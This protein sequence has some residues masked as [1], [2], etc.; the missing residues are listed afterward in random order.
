MVGRLN[1]LRRVAALGMTF[2]MLLACTTL[3]RP[4]GLPPAQNGGDGRGLNIGLSA[5]S[6]SWESA[7]RVGGV[8]GIDVSQWQGLINWS[9]V[10]Q[11]NVKYVMARAS[12]GE[13]IDTHFVYNATNAY[14]NGLRVG[15]YHYCKF[16]DETSM[17]RELGALLYQLRQVTIDFPIAVD[18]EANRG[19][20]RAELT[21]L[22]TLFAREIQAA[23]YDVMIYSYA[24][25]FRDY[26]DITSLRD[27]KLWLANYS[28][29]PALGQAMW[30]YTSHGTVYGI[31]GRVDINVLYPDWGVGYQRTVLVNADISRYIKEAINSYYSQD[32]DLNTLNMNAI[33]KAVSLALH[34]EINRQFGVNIGARSEITQTAHAYLSSIGYVKGRTQGNITWL[35]QVKLFYK[36]FFH[37]APNG[38]FDDATALAVYEFQYNNGLPA[39]GQIN[40]ET[41]WALL[42]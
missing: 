13:E 32:I 1:P 20:G 18:V 11:D 8:M 4:G 40:S 2:L 21:R 6:K 35:Y 19:L 25:F 33:N 10:A 41:L 12:I 14:A 27:Y 36:G 9:Q 29:E 38:V 28:S 3:R 34:T 22:V 24:N 30:Q 37:S 16:T 31:N 5:A 17:R 39:T 42:R 15:A 7:Q 26:L 23:G